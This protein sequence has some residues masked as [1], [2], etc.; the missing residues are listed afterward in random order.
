MKNKRKNQ[1][2]TLIELLVVITII[3]ILASVSVPVYSSVQRSARLT[4]SLS[5]A[6][7]IQIAMYAEWGKLGYIPD[8]ESGGE[9][10][11]AYLAPLIRKLKS[12]EPFFVTG[13]AWHGRGDTR[14][15]GDNLWETSEPQGT[16]LEAGENHYAVNKLSDFGPRY[17]VL[18]SGFT[19]NVG[20]YTDKKTEVGG[21]W[22]GLDAIIIYGD[23]KGEQVQLDEQFRF[24]EDK[25]GTKIDVFG[26]EEV[27]MVNPTQ[28]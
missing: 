7:G 10:A 12:E 21:V 28:G 9:D 16:A 26:Q 24:M 14:D 4:K 11:N 2:F 22:E 3:A 13:C 25:G 5:Q 27:E 19:S 17:P 18:A 23:G 15:G 6:K 20:T 8:P 1:G